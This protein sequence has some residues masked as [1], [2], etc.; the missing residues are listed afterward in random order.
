MYQLNWTEPDRTG[1]DSEYGDWACNLLIIV[2]IDPL[3]VL[4]NTDWVHV[5]QIMD[6]KCVF[7]ESSPVC[8]LQYAS[9]KIYE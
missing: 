4:Q 2:N 9:N 7:S 1:L 5:L 3:N 8:V 6:A